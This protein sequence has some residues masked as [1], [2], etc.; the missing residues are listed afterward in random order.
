MKA[1]IQRVSSASVLVEQR[2]TGAI[3]NGILL[4]LGIHTEDTEDD[5]NWLASKVASLRICSDGEG[6]MNC[7]VVETGGRALVVSQ[8]TLHARYKKGTRPSFVDAA[9]PAHAEALYKHF[10]TQLETAMG[11]RV[12]TGEFGA[13]MNVQLTNDGPVTL[14]LDTRNKE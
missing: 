10:I 3:E 5:A 12:E 2:I 11:V 14:I 13:H 7:S 6:K 9:Q 4:F 8:F 1:L